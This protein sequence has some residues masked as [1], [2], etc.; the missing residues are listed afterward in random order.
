MAVCTKVDTRRPG[1][2]CQI[3][4]QVTELKNPS[5]DWSFGLKS[6]LLS[7]I[8]AQA[9]PISAGGMD[10]RPVFS[11][12]EVRCTLTSLAINLTPVILCS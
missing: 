12:L 9:S 4:G 6:S 7:T 3:L 10:T 1:S 11:E 2:T 5:L 8:S